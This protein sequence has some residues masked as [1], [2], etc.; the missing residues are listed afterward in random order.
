[1]LI[2][3]LVT[4]GNTMCFDSCSRRFGL[5]HCC[6]PRY[7]SLMPGAYRTDAIGPL[8]VSKVRIEI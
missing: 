7:V 1:M 3:L 6:L 2:C 4:S 5:I 8:S